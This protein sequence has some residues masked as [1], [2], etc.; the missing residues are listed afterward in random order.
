MAQ[1]PTLLHQ[2]IDDGHRYH[3]WLDPSIHV[4]P[5]A[6][7]RLRPIKSRWYTS[8]FYDTYLQAYGL[9]PYSRLTDAA[10]KFML[11]SSLQSALVDH[12]RPETHTFHLRYGE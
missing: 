5:P 9:L 11:D 2:S 8:A 1:L 3:I 12:W 4:H 10:A 6:T 7:F